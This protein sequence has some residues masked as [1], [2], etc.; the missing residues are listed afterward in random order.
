[1]I[2]RYRT[3]SFNASNVARPR[4]IVSGSAPDCFN[5]R[6]LFICA[7]LVLWMMCVCARLVYLQIT[8]SAQLHA[9]AQTQ[10]QGTRP[11]EAERG[12]IL[13]RNGRELARSVSVTSIFTVPNEIEDVKNTAKKIASVTGEDAAT[14]TTKIERAKRE[15]KKFIWLA[16]KLNDAIAVRIVNLNLKGIRTRAESKRFYPN[17]SLAAHIVG[18][19]GLDENGLGGIEQTQNKKLAGDD[20]KIF[21]NKDARRQAY[22]TTE[23]AARDGGSIVLTIDL[24]I[25]YQ[26][27]QILRAAVAQ[28]RARS[29]TV[30]VLDPRNGEVLALANAPTFNPNDV[31]AKA[32]NEISAKEKKTANVEH[33]KL[34]VNEALQNIYEPG[35]TF[36]IV[37]YAGA[38]EEGLARPDEK[39]DCQMGSI[40]VAGRKINDH[41]PYGT[42]TLT[43]ALAKSSNVAAIKL[44]LRLGNQR[45]HDYAT[46]FGFGSRT[47]IDLPG[48]TV[49]L[50]RP[51]NRWQASSI[52]SIAI[53]QEI[54]ATPLQMVSAFATIANDGVRVAPHIVRGVQKSD[55]NFIPTSPA[56]ATRVTSEGTARALRFMLESVTLRGTAKKAQLDGYTAAG[57]T[58]TAQK[59]D[60]QTRAYSKT[61][62]VAS[63]AGFAPINNPSV[64]IVV[65][66]DEPIG[67]YHG[68]DAAAPVFRDIAAQILPFLNVLPDADFKENADG[69]LN[70]ATSTMPTDAR[71]SP[72]SDVSQNNESNDDEDSDDVMNPQPF[73]RASVAAIN[74]RVVYTTA[75]ERALVMPD[76]RGMSVRDAWQVCARLGLQFEAVGEGN[77]SRQKPLAG[78]SVDAGEVVRVTFDKSG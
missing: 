7:L 36:K 42:L 49:G 22:Q 24:A 61:K 56:P 23:V 54:G 29:G 13:D 40:N 12:L 46:R 59:I 8:Q 69:N 41:H 68:G 48:E 77:V 64:A 63:F 33:Q 14:L 38:I 34:R 60:P 53:G 25:Q 11:L 74:A 44:G 6:A 76:L 18:F 50:L 9:I 39:I 21:L 20:G 75:G 15:R 28:S 65:V 47:G 27:E 67:A 57:K 19:V 43:D 55:G 16:R 30:I 45:L 35:S 70:L 78:A 66:L 51:A 37:A 17:N 31:G 4:F 26:T 58:G 72:S 73:E 1:M 10:Q 71:T 3:S 2:H 52:G 32:E 5:R 62:Y